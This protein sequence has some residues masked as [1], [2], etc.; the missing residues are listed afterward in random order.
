MGSSLHRSS[1]VRCATQ[2]GLSALRRGPEIHFAGPLPPGTFA[3]A[4]RALSGHLSLSRPSPAS[5]RRP[6]HFRAGNRRCADAPMRRCKGAS[7]AGPEVDDQ[8]ARATALS[9]PCGPPAEM[10]RSHMPAPHSCADNVIA[11]YSALGAG[12]VS[13][14]RNLPAGFLDRCRSCSWQ[15]SAGDSPHRRSGDTTLERH[16]PGW[17]P[18]PMLQASACRMPLPVARTAGPLT[19]LLVRL[20]SGDGCPSPT[21]N[22]K[23]GTPTKGRALTPSGSRRGARA[24]SSRRGV[25]GSAQAGMCFKKPR[26]SGAARRGSARGPR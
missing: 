5:S 8:R 18:A 1:D 6:G 17:P 4:P 3:A 15:A 23:G 22:G 26:P 7:R 2:H 25:S 10:C 21:R 24:A 16:S 19:A 14:K 13:S 20:L 11:P 9:T 12:V